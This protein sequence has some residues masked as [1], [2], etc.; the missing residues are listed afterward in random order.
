VSSAAIRT[1]A[2]WTGD[3]RDGSDIALLKLDRPVDASS[4]DIVRDPQG[5]IGETIT[6]TGYGR[7]GSGVEGSGGIGFGT[8]RIG[9]NR[10]DTRWSA[11][12]VAGSPFAFDFDDGSVA[13][14]T[15]G[16]SVP[17][18]RDLGT[19]LPEVLIAP[20][21]S[22]GPS[23]LNGQIVGIHSFGAT[24]G[25]PFDSDDSLNSSFGELAG[26]V[27]VAL[28]AD[29]FDAVTGPVPEPETYLLMIVG[30]IAVARA[31]HNGRFGARPSDPPLAFRR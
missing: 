20:G 8:L 29:W 7:S 3:F 5:G 21:D 11:T 1:P 26:D 17:L 24:F 19:G 13:R 22:G 30:L 12:S 6:V 4:Y 2:T 25:A 31:A 16:N 28:F 23:F 10:Y 14:D 15:I 9:S 27:R 18:L